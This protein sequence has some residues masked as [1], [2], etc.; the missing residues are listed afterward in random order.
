MHTAKLTDMLDGV[1]IGINT[2]CMNR[3]SLSERV[4]MLDLL[5]TG[6]TLRAIASSTGNSKNT[7]DKLLT[8]VGRACLA[9]HDRYVLDVRASRVV[10]D[11]IWS[12]DTKAE[13]FAAGDPLINADRKAWT[14]T[15][16]DA[17]SKMVIFYR[18]GSRDAEFACVFCNQVAT[19]LSRRFQLA[20]D[21]CT[22]YLQAVEGSPTFD[23]E[24]T[25]LVRLYGPKTMELDVSKLGGRS[26]RTVGESPS[27][28][29]AFLSAVPVDRHS[30]RTDHY[31]YAI[32]FHMMHY[33]F[34][35]LQNSDCMTPAMTA[36]ITD[37]RWEISDLAELMDLE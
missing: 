26:D 12:F 21:E 31:T 24:Y 18:V 13:M 14:W 5:S 7:V 27:Y 4:Q 10:L 34:V 11:V 17:I 9:Y 33:N 6:M 28:E 1:Q 16:T 19:R 8:D 23:F 37:R 15:A 25:D 29:P 22:T 3:L 35:A 2:A 36:G 20:R 32:A 30:Q